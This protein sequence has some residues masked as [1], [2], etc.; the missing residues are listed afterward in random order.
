MTERGRLGI[1]FLAVAWALE[2][3]V[4]VFWLLGKFDG[5]PVLALAVVVANPLVILWLVRRWPG[6]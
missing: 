4:V 2:A 6:R 3:A 5:P 1:A